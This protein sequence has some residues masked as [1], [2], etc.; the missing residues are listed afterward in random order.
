MDAQAKGRRPF[1]LAGTFSGWIAIILQFY[2]ILIHRDASVRET[3]IRYF[4]FFTI[5]TNILFTVCF[6]FLLISPDSGPGK[7]FSRPATLA[8]IA[9]YM[10]V[11]GIIYNGVLRF[12][13][14]PRG[15]QWFADELLHVVNPVCFLLFWIFYVPK[16]GLQWKQAFIW[17]LYPVIYISLILFRGSFSGF[18]PYPFSNVRKLGYHRVFLNST[19]TILVFLVIALLFVLIGKRQEKLKK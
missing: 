9:V 19:R 16:T 8:A 4:S 14:N 3:I 15:F 2:L 7:F 13:W 6:T 11:V 12:L 10:A 5:L 18:Y 1:L 17:M